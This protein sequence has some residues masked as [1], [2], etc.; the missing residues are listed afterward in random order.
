MNEVDSSGSKEYWPSKVGADNPTLPSGLGGSSPHA[1]HPKFRGPAGEK[2]GG[3][4]V[5][6]VSHRGIS[7]V[8]M[9][10]SNNNQLQL[11]VAPEKATD[12]RA[13]SLVDWVLLS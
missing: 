9:G 13:H 4:Q 10:Q 7:R 2:A 6:G 3:G 11:F 5:F 1:P 8:C 12:E